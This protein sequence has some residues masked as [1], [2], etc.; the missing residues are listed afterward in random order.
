MMDVSDG[1]GTPSVTYER[2]ISRIKQTD[3]ILVEPE[4]EEE[5]PQ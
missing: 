5:Y 2:K 4:P 3:E 1:R